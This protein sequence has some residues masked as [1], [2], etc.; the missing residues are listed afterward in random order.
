MSANPDQ[1]SALARL[2]HWLQTAITHPASVEAGARAAGDAADQLVRPSS[3]MQPLA[4][5]G[6]YHDAYFARLIDCLADDYPALRSVLGPDRFGAL[7]RRYLVQ[8]PPRSPSLNDYGNAL[9]ELA[10]SEPDGAVLRDL[11]RIEWAC[12]ELVHA[13][14][15]APVSAAELLA[16][17][18]TFAE[19][20][21]VPVPA[22][23]LLHLDHP[24]HALY[25]ALRAGRSA[26]LPA[27]EPAFVLV[28]RPEWAVTTTVLSP[29]EGELLASL[30]A[31]TAVGT[32]LADAAQRGASETDVGAWFQRWLAAG[33]FAS[34]A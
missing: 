26:Q 22:L 2:Q 4:R 29:P 23:R 32:A 25:L 34:L 31:G 12:A 27:P 8:R 18:A 11:A 16:R 30:L 14:Q 21:L 20:R 1:A 6:V 28:H 13:P 24:V 3:R 5:V 15:V 19:A 17:E 10:V 33:M 7:C 9:P